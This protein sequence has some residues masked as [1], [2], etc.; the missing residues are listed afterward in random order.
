M[1]EKANVQA[2]SKYQ[3]CGFSACEGCPL[4]FICYAENEDLLC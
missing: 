3:D 1:D 2:E 4:A